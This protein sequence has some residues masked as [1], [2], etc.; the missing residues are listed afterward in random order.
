MISHDRLWQAIWLPA[1]RVA[2]AIVARLWWRRPPE[3]ISARLEAR[4]LRD[5]ATIVAAVLTGLFLTSLVFAHAGILG[6]LVFLLLVIL[7]I[8]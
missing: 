4:P 3:E 6:M 5:Q 7:L 1:R 8:R 2:F